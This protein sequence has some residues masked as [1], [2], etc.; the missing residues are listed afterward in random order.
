MN[1]CDD[2]YDE[3]NIKYIRDAIK[4]EIP[5]SSKKAFRMVEKS[6]APAEVVISEESRKICA[7]ILTQ[8]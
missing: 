7:K 6:P 8:P 4:R 5:G 1:K 2:N 3:A